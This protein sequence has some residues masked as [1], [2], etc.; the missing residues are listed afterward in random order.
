MRVALDT[1]PTTR[2]LKLGDGRDVVFWG[3]RKVVE[4]RGMEEGS[5]VSIFWSGPRQDSRSEHRRVLTRYADIRLGR[6]LVAV[7]AITK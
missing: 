2:V 3:G 5:E 6:D 4:A 1:Q 7:D